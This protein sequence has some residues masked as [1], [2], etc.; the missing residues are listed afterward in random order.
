MSDK[1][2]QR[3]SPRLK[4]FDYNSEYAYFITICTK[5]R[6]C[7]LSRIVGTG[8]LTCPYKQGFYALFF[9]F[10]IQTIVHQTIRTQHLANA[11]LRPHHS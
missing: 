4:G 11:I 9:C 1:L 5:D 7:L 6:R 8:V 3:K 10:F 2:P